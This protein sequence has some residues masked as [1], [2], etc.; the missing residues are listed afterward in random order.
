MIYNYSII[1]PYRDKYDM[2]ITAIGSVPDRE[3][4]QVIIVDNAPQPLEKEQIPHKNK[5]VITYVTSSPT[6]GAGCA[7]NVGLQYVEGA[8]ILFLDADDYF[9]NTAFTAFDRYIREDFDIVYF[10]AD[11]I[12]LNTGFRSVRHEHIEK[13]ISDY[14][15]TNEE[16]LLRY[17][18][19]NPIAKL[20]KTAFILN[21]NIKFD[22][23]R[24]SNDVWFSMKTGHLAKHVTA[25]RAVVYMITEGGIGSSLTKS[26]NKDN[27]F[28]R[29][30]V[31][32]KVNKF[33]KEVDAYK[34]HTRLSGFIRI[35]WKEFGF[36]EFIRFL[37]YAVDNRVS[38]F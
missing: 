31:M 4:I 32:V 26:L 11:S 20:F 34:Y 5:A 8:F 28:I 37:K 9:T 38:I 17:G 24:V 35:A 23:T 13:R 21:N 10:C 27:W 30:Q 29:F 19:V 15:Q 1:L 18:I 2:F 25:S 6:K 16:G 3:D 14:L 7:R 22:E 36:K 12:N 33:L